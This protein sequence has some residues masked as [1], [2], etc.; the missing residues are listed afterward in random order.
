[1]SASAESVAGC[2][3]AGVGQRFAEEVEQY[4]PSA[5]VAVRIV[6]HPVDPGHV[7]DVFDRPRFEQRAPGFYA[8][9]RP[10]SY[11]ENHVVIV[12]VA[13]PDREPQVVTDLQQDAPA[14]V[15]RD[16]APVSAGVFLVLAAVSEEVAFVVMHRRTVGT[17]EIEPVEVAA[18]LFYGYAAG[19]R[20]SF[21]PGRPS[22][23]CQSR[24]SVRFG[25]F[26]RAGAPGREHFR[27]YDEVGFS[28][29]KDFPFETVA[30][31]GRIVPDKIGLY[32]GDVHKFFQKRY[33]LQ[34]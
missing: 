25:G 11:V 16:H 32:Q 10:A 15:F 8:R 9:R 24:P 26:A 7:A 19:Q 22:H 30:V 27:Q 33:I 20:G 6:S 2:P 18:V 3:R 29:R 28:D 1:M 23:P 34:K 13:R 17:D 4:S 12:P 31:G 21:L 5:V 14:F